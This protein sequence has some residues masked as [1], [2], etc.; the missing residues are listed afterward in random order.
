MSI[1]MRLGVV[2][3]GVGMVI[4]TARAVESDCDA[5]LNGVRKIGVIG[6]PGT[7]VPVGPTA[8]PLVVGECG[9]A[10]KGEPARLAPVVSGARLG[11][12]RIV[13][14]G[15]DG[16]LNLKNQLTGDTERLLLNAIRWAAGAPNQ[17]LSTANVRVA[18]HNKPELLRMLQ[19]QQRMTAIA[20]DGKSWAKS[21]KYCQ[22]FCADTS[23]DDDPALADAVRDFVKAGGGLV[24]AGTGWGWAQIHRKSLVDDYLGQRVLLPAGLVVAS[25]GAGATT[26]G[27]YA[28]LNPPPRLASASAALDALSAGRPIGKEDLEQVMHILTVAMQALPADDSQFVPRLR[29]L[30]QQSGAVPMPKAPIR[31]NQVAARLAVTLEDLELLH[32]KPEQ[33][34]AHPAAAGFPG[35]VPDVAPRV[36]K[37]IDIDT[38]I[39][40]WHSLGLYAA[41]G[42]VITVTVPASAA[43]KHLGVRIGPH[44]D[45]LWRLPAWSRWPNLSRVTGL[46]PPETRFASPFGGVVYINVPEREGLGTISVAVAGAVESPYYVLGKT[47]LAEWRNRIRKLPGPWAELECPGVIVTVPSTSVRNLDDPER[48]MKFWNRA[49]ELQDNL[50]G[51]KPE[52]RKKPERF[53]TDQQISAGYMHSGYPI[54]AGN[55]MYDYNVSVASLVGTSHKPGGWGQWHELGHNHQSSDWTPSGTGEVTVNLFTMYVI[56]QLYDVPLDRVRGEKWT[57]AHRC[58]TLAGYLASN[59]NPSN[60]DPFEG[61][62]LYHQLIDAFG[63]D[64]L[65]KV[66]AGYRNS[67]QGERLKTD[68]DKWDQWMVRYSKAVNKNLGPFFMKWKCPVTRSALDSIKSLP[69]WMHPDFK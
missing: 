61:L 20:A 59:R 53:V 11:K 51:W 3:A 18:V 46:E 35:L 44:T 60:W 52:D 31:E 26:E 38:G 14:F 4:P 21:L 67:G 57:R 1:L 43:G 24:T 48:L 66:I 47:S 62:I 9:H 10:K 16:Y 30:V 65:K 56:N 25:Q 6:S 23:F 68:A 2:W 29:K 41:P 28:V 40:G 69:P 45:H 19:S 49:V 32:L 55:D 63:W 34:R 36:S 54:M 22:V 8:F 17:K 27:G 12:G 37:S 5:L 33:V 58:Q 15:H 50:A 13:A 39:L 7:V 64:A 42:E